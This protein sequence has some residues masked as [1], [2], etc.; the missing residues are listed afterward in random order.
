VNQAPLSIAKDGDLWERLYWGGF[1]SVQFPS[2]ETFWLAHVAP[3]T[4]RRT[5]QLYPAST[6][7]TAA[8]SIRFRTDAELALDQALAFTTAMRERA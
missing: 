6:E 4:N 7:T 8:A 5:G 1:A 2:Y 3:L